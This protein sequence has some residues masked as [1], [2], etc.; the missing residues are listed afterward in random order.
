MCKLILTFLEDF[1]LKFCYTNCPFVNHRY[2]VMELCNGTLKNLIEDQQLGQ[3]GDD[4]KRGIMYQ[5]ANGLL[6]L[7]QNQIAHRD[8]KP[9]NILFKLIPL[10]D[11]SVRMVMKLADLGIS[12]I[13]PDGRSQFTLTNLKG[14]N[15]WLAPEMCGPSFD[16]PKI[17]LEIDIFP[18]GLV[19]V[20]ILLD[21]EYA[22]GFNAEQYNQRLREEKPRMLQEV[23]TALK[24]RGD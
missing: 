22:F 12:R 8:L 21:G 23:E 10:S 15:C 4:V 5:F 18:L 2:I 14:T 24:N 20:Y 11:G 17:R 6:I 13:A 7:H 1:F 19:F 9:Q 16:L 3:L